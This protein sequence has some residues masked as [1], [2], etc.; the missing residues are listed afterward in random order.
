MIYVRRLLLPCIWAA[1][2]C[3]T[4]ETRAKSKRVFSLLRPAYHLDFDL[5]T[6]LIHKVWTAFD[7]PNTT[8]NWW[9][10]GPPTGKELML[11][12]KPDAG[13]GG[14]GGGGGGRGGGG[15]MVSYSDFE[16]IWEGEDLTR[17]LF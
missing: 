4:K 17:Q 3:T 16:R 15:S 11:K 9:T 2:F 13:L 10:C 7:T 8:Q 6:R 14:G 12:D 5:T 1:S